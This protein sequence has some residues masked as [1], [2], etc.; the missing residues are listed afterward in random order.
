MVEVLYRS[1]LTDLIL[2]LDVP[3]CLM[4][5]G[6]RLDDHELRTLLAATPT[7]DT[8]MQTLFERYHEQ[9]RQ[10]G[11]QEGEA[12]VL[13]RQIERKFGPPS[14]AVRERISQADPETLLAWSE[15]ILTA[16]ALDTVLH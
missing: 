8:T 5:A 10:E 9:G 1:R 15:R 2:R 3:R 6:R 13:L 7:G 16:E 14:A 11:W 4:L 12:A